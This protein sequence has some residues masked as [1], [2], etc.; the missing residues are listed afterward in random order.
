MKMEGEDHQG[1]KGWTEVM[2]KYFKNKFFIKGGSW[3]NMS[4]LT[5]T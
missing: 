2:E 4:L 3:Q 5:Y 1:L